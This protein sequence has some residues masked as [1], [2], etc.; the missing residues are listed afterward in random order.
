MRAAH[1]ARLIAPSRS[2]SAC[3][4]MKPLGVHLIVGTLVILERHD[5]H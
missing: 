3:N 2:R 4:L 1:V 5:L